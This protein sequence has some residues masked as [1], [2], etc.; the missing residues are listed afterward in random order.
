MI[1]HRFA[2]GIVFGGGRLGGVG[3]GGQGGGGAGGGGGWLGAIQP[4]LNSHDRVVQNHT[5]FKAVDC[6]F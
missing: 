6:F 4:L 1:N 2:L 5:K 3:V